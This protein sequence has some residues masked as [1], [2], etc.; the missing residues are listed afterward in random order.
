MNFHCQACGAHNYKPVLSGS[1]FRIISCSSCGLFVR[2]PQLKDEEIR[3]FYNQDY[4]RSWGLDKDKDSVSEMKKATA[5][6]RLA[7]IE[8][9]KEKGKILDVGCAAGGDVLEYSAGLL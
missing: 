3:E 1:A 8:R 6:K 2:D 5:K 9:Y 7:E 4:Y